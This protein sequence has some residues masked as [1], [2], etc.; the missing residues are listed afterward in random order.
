MLYILCSEQKYYFWMVIVIGKWYW[1]G[2][3][4]GQMYT[5]RGFSGVND[6]WWTCGVSICTHHDGPINLTQTITWSRKA[7]MHE[8]VLEPDLVGFYFSSIYNIGIHSLFTH[9]PVL[10][11]VQFIK[12]CI[13]QVSWRIIDNGAL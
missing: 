6:C 3:R 9:S 5:L 2:S 11:Q 12:Y 4:V 7:C 8:I 10:E 1:P 13:Y